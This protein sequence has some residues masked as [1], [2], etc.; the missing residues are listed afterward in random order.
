MSENKYRCQNNLDGKCSAMCKLRR[1]PKRFSRAASK[2]TDLLR[3]EIP[4]MTGGEK[5]MLQFLF[6]TK[7]VDCFMT[8]VHN[9][10]FK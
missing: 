6:W 3:M 7:M 2:E 8:A 9:G 5:F 4:A 1:P 10:W